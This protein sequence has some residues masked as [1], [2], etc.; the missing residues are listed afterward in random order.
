MIVA[1]LRLVTGKNA[2]R[3]AI[4]ANQ[5]HRQRGSGE[6]DR[7]SMTNTIPRTYPDTQNSSRRTGGSSTLAMAAMA[8][9]HTPT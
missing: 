9:R 1:E 5:T 6:A 4:L 3:W 7:T 8:A 2:L